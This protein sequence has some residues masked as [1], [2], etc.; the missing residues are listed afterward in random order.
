M[1]KLITSFLV[2]AMIYQCAQPT[3]ETITTALSD[4]SLGGY[5]SQVEYGKHLINIMGCNDCHTPKKMGPQG[6]EVDSSLLLSGYSSRTPKV[7]IDKLEIQ[8]KGY[9]ISLD[10][11]EWVG[12][13]GTTY[14]ANLTPDPTG[15]GNWT[16]E[17]FK[18][19]LKKGK[20]KG[21]ENGR[22]LLPPMPIATFVHCTD[23]ELEAMYAYLKSIHPVSNM[24]PA[25]V[26]PVADEI[27]SS[28]KKKTQG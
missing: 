24:V 2:L 12:P 25:V 9:G 27:K 1:Y 22:A 26:P 18:V 6:P 21:L 20:H 5:S 10:L 3:K 17:N 16:I 13:W 19:A 7:E 23:H 14:A 15:I 11:T 4:P 8:K 28:A